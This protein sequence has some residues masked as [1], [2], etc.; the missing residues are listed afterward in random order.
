MT[1]KFIERKKKEFS[2]LREEIRILEEEVGIISEKE[3]I[4]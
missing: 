3:K 4:D 2:A 1:Y